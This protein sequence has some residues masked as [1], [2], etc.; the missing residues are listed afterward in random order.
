M[1]RIFVRFK[2]PEQKID[3]L[4]GAMLGKSA[5]AESKLSFALP[6]TMHIAA[7]DKVRKRLEASGV[8]IFDDIQFRAFP[9]DTED[10]FD[11][12]SYDNQAADLADDYSLQDVVS[13]I[14]APEAWER[15]RGAGAT[16]AIVDTGI[17]GALQ[18]FS[19]GRRVPL[20]IESEYQGQHWTDTEG[21]GSMCAAIAA[22][23]R[24]DGG[25]H[26]G[27]APDAKVIAARSSLKSSD[28][29][30]IY[31]DLIKA[32]ALGTIAGPL[33]VSNSYGLYTCT[34]PDVMPEDHP[35]MEAILN[36][37]RSG[38][39]VCFAAGNNHYDVLCGHDPRDSGPNTIWG[40]NSHDEVVSVGT[41]NRDLTNC[42]PATP[43]ANS[44]RGP[45]EWAKAT[46][47]P[48]C[49][50]PTYGEVIWGT[51][52][53]KMRWWGTSGACPQVAGLAALILSVQPAA[54]PAQVGDI[55]RQSCSRLPES[56]NCVGHGLIDCASA[57]DMATALEPGSPPTS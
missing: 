16:I 27:V 40:P 55:I 52:L 36:A 24:T 38:V 13:Q 5:A 23:S 28:L 9:D 4:S 29:F 19:Q 32:R 30:D 12:W 11:R 1:Q 15:T 3:T 53:R 50:A 17:A 39:F 14:R 42:D 43:H 35:Y 21:H 45:G 20:D 44:S 37:I 25:R 56:P 2:S 7:T 26:D 51:S 54:S 34:A 41:V 47:K 31:D 48:D 46:R 8:E 57:L 18:E 6:D 10:E 33:V 22:A 49:V